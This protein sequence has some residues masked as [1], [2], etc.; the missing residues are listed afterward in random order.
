MKNIIENLKNNFLFQASLGSKE[1]FHSNLLAWLLE[2]KCKDGS[3]SVLEKF[4]KEFANQEV[5]LKETQF[6]VFREKDNIDLLIEWEQN[7]K[8][9][10]I[11]IENKVKSLPKQ[12]QL[13]S[14][15]GKIEKIAKCKIKNLPKDRIIKSFLLTPLKP[16]IDLENEKIK[17]WESISYE[18]DI[19]PFLEQISISEL[20]F[21]NENIGFVIHNYL[22]FLKNLIELFKCFKLD[23]FSSFVKNEYNIYAGENELIGLADEIRIRDLIVKLFH[24]NIGELIRIKLKDLENNFDFQIVHDHPKDSFKSGNIF[25]TSGFTRSQ[26][27]TDIK[28]CFEKNLLLGIQLQGNSL[29]FLTEIFGGKTL[30]DRN[31]KFAENL[32]KERIWFHDKEG[33]PYSGK[34]RNS[35]L[36]VPGHDFSFNSY[37]P[38]FIYLNKDISDYKDCEIDDLTDFIVEQ[39]IKIFKERGKFEEAVK[40]L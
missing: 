21:V 22:D 23:D 13:V 9:N 1:L 38:K 10:Y 39:V 19:I 27:L 4:I 12:N 20:V 40:K 31:I 28:I 35:K 2:Q 33:N 11:F 8:K 14:Y 6:N 24:D 7:N 30:Q 26:G 25:I 32:F 15:N 34:G 16:N 17:N 5:E 29:K 18:N 37:T 3:Y 36:M